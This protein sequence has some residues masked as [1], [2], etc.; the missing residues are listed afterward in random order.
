MEIFA[1]ITLLGFISILVLSSFFG[2]RGRYNYPGDMADYNY[3]PRDMYRM[4][5]PPD[6]YYWRSREQ[7]SRII[8]T[9]IFVAVLFAIIAFLSKSDGLDDASIHQEAPKTEMYASNKSL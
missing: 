8:S 1:I 9:L 4:P 5:P 7:S 2:L 3:Y 6:Y